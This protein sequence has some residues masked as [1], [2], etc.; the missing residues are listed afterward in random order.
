MKEI[1]LLGVLFT[2]LQAQ[3][4]WCDNTR[5]PARVQGQEWRSRHDGWDGE[6]HDRRQHEEQ[7]HS[8]FR[9]NVIIGTPYQTPPIYYSQP[10]VYPQPSQVYI[11]PGSGYALY[12][13]NPAGYFPTI[14]YC[15]TKWQQVIPYMAPR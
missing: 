14:S 7:E 12:C 13:P 9:G 10:P 3:T 2:L 5:D 15:S 11:E 1:T 4:G 6:R 8:R